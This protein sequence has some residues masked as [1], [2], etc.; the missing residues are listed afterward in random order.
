MP[1]DVEKRGGKYRVIEK[2]TGKIAT[3]KSGKARDGGGH[4]RPQKAYTQS[5][6][7]SSGKRK[8]L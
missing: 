4:T 5:H 8:N 1:T 6:Y 2:G 7:I 3:T